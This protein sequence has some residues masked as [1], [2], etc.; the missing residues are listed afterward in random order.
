MI[1]QSAAV[2]ESGEHTTHADRLPES[3]VAREW[4]A[5]LNLRF[6]PSASKTILRRSHRGPLMVQ[7]PFY[8]E[9][10]TCHAYVLHPPAG[11]VGGDHLMVK[12]T[13]Q[14]G[15]RGLVTTPGAAKFYGSDGRL[16]QQE[17]HISV[18]DSM[19]EWLPQETI[20]Y[21]RCN[22]KQITRVNLSAE[23]RFIGWEV[24]CFGRPAGDQLFESGRISSRMEIYM[25]GTALLLE[26]LKVTGSADLEMNSGMRSASV[27]ATMI[28]ISPGLYAAEL[29]D[30]VRDTFSRKDLFSATL[31][32]SLLVIRYLGHS[33]EEARYGFICVWHA[34]RPTIIQRQVV[35]PRI[36]AT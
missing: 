12:A 11:I 31:I 3:S 4:R 19:L 16:A 36:W 10:E 21:N 28:A 13:C 35:V 20:F 26:R 30:R 23:S 14:S 33:A 29:L 6:E 2:L 22:A 17:Q 24:N 32:D 8:P 25:E 27:N 15:A 34:L 9:G 7:R 18:G 1:N 5:S